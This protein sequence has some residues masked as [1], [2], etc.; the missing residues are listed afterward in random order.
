MLKI[1]FKDGLPVRV[2]NADDGTGARD[3]A[4]SGG[5]AGPTLPAATPAD[6]SDPL[7]VYL[8]LNKIG[9]AHG[10]GR[11]DVVENRFVGIK[12]RG[13]YESPGAEIL[14]AAH[15]GLEGQSSPS[16][17]PLCSPP[18][19]SRAPAPPPPPLCRAGLTLD[20]EVFRLRDTL[21]ARFA[22]LCYNGASGCRCGGC[23]GSCWL[24]PEPAHRTM[25]CPQPLPGFWFSPEMEFILH[26]VRKSQEVRRGR[27]R[28]CC[29]HR[30]PAASAR[31]RRSASRAP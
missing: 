21:S 14:R 22:D 13:V 8:Y 10:V 5:L 7:D 6:L 17:A 18:H 2:E 27:P 11:V 16:P 3:A 23:G 19:Y 9:G 24:T 30:A 15:V 20:R 29:T 1:H 28:A 4:H 25:A 12:S 26:A 31:P